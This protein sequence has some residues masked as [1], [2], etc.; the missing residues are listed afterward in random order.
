[1]APHQQQAQPQPLN[2]TWFEIYTQ[3]EQRQKIQYVSFFTEI[4]KVIL[5]ILK[6]TTW[7]QIVQIVPE[8]VLNEMYAFFKWIL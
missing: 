8:S 2:S 5:I 6:H 7:E 1:M 4:V 3:L